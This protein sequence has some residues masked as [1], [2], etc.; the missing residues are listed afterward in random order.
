M[1]QMKLCDLVA[2][3]KPG[4]I[5]DFDLSSYEKKMQFNGTVNKFL[6]SVHYRAFQTDRVLSFHITG[7]FLLGYV[8]HIRML[9]TEIE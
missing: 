9:P 2:C 6:E 5:I 7:D 1:A 8:A 4:V 3:L